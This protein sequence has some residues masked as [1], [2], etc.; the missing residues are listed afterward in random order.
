[1]H[2]ADPFFFQRRLC[3][4]ADSALLPGDGSSANKF[5][6]FPGDGSASHSQGP[7]PVVIEGLQYFRVDCYR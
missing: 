2:L 4:L 5:G 3:R 1:M 6:F 7:I